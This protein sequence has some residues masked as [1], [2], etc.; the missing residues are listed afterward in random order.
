[1][2]CVSDATAPPENLCAKYLWVECW[3]DSKVEGGT[4]MLNVWEMLLRCITTASLLLSV[5]ENV[6]VFL[7]SSINDK[8]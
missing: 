2:C 1:M 6:M 7:F 3:C 4:R 5:L 8:L